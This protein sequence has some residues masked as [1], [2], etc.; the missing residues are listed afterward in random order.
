MGENRKGR[1]KAGEQD[2]MGKK[3]E[4]PPPLLTIPAKAA[5]SQGDESGLECPAEPWEFLG[6]SPPG[7]VGVEW[8]SPANA[9]AGE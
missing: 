4:L 9:E 8:A 1:L 7:Q 3:K 6:P 5:T 2:G